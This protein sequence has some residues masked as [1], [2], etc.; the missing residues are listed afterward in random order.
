[1]LKS[2]K[3]KTVDDLKEKLSLTRSLIL[4]DFRGLNVEDLSRLRRDLKKGGAEYRITKNTLIRM[5]ARESGYEAIVDYLKGPTGLVFSYQD[6]ISPAKVLYEFL[7]KSDKPKIKT[8]WL[9]GK[10]FGENQLKRLATLP[11]KEVVLTQIVGSLNAP[12]ANF[13]GTLQ[14]MLRNLVGVIDAIKETRTQ[15]A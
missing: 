1:M 3:E 13:V 10:L 9:E 12:M 7:L 5:A 8:I 4:T 15:A 11:S 14:G 2:E 6:P